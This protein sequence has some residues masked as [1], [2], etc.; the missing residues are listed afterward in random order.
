MINHHHRLAY[1]VLFAAILGIFAGVF[2]GSLT[3]I[4]KPIGDAF[5]MLL[6]MIVLPYISFSL[7]H[8]LGSLSPETAKGLFKKAW[9][10]WALLWGLMFAIVFLMNRLIPT[11][12][13]GVPSAPGAAGELSKHILTYLVPENPFYDLANNIVPAIAVFGLIIGFALMHVEKKEPL[14]STLERCNQVIE[15]I[16][17]WLAAISPVGVFAHLAVSAGRVDFQELQRLEFYVFGFI[18]I[19]LFVTFWILPAILASFTPIGYRETI[20]AYRKVCLLAFVTGLPTLSIP[21]INMYLASFEEKYKF[22]EP[23]FRVTSQTAMP[24][25]FAFGQIGNCLL[26]YF[27]LFSSFYYRHPFNVGEKCLVSLLTIPLSVGSSAASVSAVSFLITQLGFPE[28]AI[29][30]FSATRVITENFQVLISVAS[31]MTLT[32][33]IL[34]GYFGLLKIRWTTLFW[35]I[36]GGFGC[37]AAG[38]FFFGP[39]IH[40]TDDLRNLYSSFQLSAVIDN[41]PKTKVYKYGEEIPPRPGAQQVAGSETLDRILATGLLRV[42]YH[43]GNIP[44]SYFNDQGDLVGYDIAMAY[45]LAKDLDCRLEFIPIDIDHL[46]QQLDAGLYDV[47]MSAIMMT[48]ERIREMDFSRIYSQQDNVLVVPLKNRDLFT[49]LQSVVKRPGLVIGAVGAYQTIL[50]RHFPL[51]TKYEGSTIDDLVNSHVQAWLWSTVSAYIWCIGHPDYTVMQYDDLLGKAFYA[52]PAKTG[53]YDFI[54]LVNNWIELKTQSG[55]VKTQYDYWILGE[56]PENAF[57][58]RWSIIRNVLHWIR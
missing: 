41:P 46:G 22:E 51:A 47:V 9:H 34:F 28:R 43:P 33:L 36:G 50:A 40:P 55:F 54:S 38:I 48:E 23:G 52:Y 4:F 15:R 2:L 24:L 32:I 11:P 35:R 5:I 3:N 20:L 13:T 39:L 14:I 6:Q 45:S 18:G 56:K 8:G 1:W 16:L 31:I 21:F 49:N 27:I 58:Q 30:M 42:G 19:A 37:M 57:Q 44:Y 10:F 26:L 17:N 53:S 12:Q 7:M 29:E 25:A